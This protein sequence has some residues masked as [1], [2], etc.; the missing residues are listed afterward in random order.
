MGGMVCQEQAYR[1]VLSQ[2]DT[3]GLPTN[4]MEGLLECAAAKDLLGD[5]LSPD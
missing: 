5:S 3:E 2:L 1:R 4:G